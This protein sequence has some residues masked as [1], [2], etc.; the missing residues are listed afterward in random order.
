MT[1]VTVLNNVNWPNMKYVDF[2]FATKFVKYIIKYYFQ[3]VSQQN[4]R[5]NN[6]S[7]LVMDILKLRNSLT[8][9]LYYLSP[10]NS[11]NDDSI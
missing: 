8:K 2:F 3:L 1:F 10:P 4:K 7:F 9:D 5:N 11:Q 6:Y